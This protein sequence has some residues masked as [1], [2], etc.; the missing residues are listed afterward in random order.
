MPFRDQMA[1]SLADPMSHRQRTAHS[2]QRTRRF[3]GGLAAVLAVRTACTDHEQPETD[4][5]AV[6]LD[7]SEPARDANLPSVGGALDDQ[8]PHGG[9]GLR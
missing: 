2:G 9:A 1:A 6:A 7:T 8:R 5:V 3:A 4:V